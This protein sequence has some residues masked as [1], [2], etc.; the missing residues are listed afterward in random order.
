[1][2]MSEMSENKAWF[3]EDNGQ[4]KG[5]VDHQEI[6]ELIKI[7]KITYGTLV[8]RSGFSEWQNVENTDLKSQLAAFSPPHLPKRHKN[9]FSL[10]GRISLIAICVLGVVFYYSLEKKNLDFNLSQIEITDERVTT[11]YG[12]LSIIGESYEKKILWDDREIY[13]SEGMGMSLEKAFSFE[14]EDVVLVQEFNGGAAC[15]A[16]FFFVILNKKQAPKLTPGFGTCSDL[17][18]TKQDGETIQV[19]M[20]GFAGP[21]ETNN[22]RRRA[23]ETT[24]IY[25]LN[26]GNV[27]EKIVPLLTDTT[28]NLLTQKDINIISTILRKSKQEA[29]IN[30]QKASCYEAAIA[31]RER[32]LVIQC[33]T[34]ETIAFKNESVSKEDFEARVE[35][36]L[37]ILETDS[38]KRQQL[39]Q[40]ILTF[41]EENFSGNIDNK[42]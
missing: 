13:I 14:Q 22:T 30:S 11:S 3:F 2:N 19:S 27:E 15:P 32:S 33:A 29:N 4:K 37:A 28:K 23:A 18:D 34:L 7:G 5:P 20:P 6:I 12:V 10:W 31:I 24:H 8:W 17:A 25:R 26:Q 1:M 41:V 9:N 39:R 35:N 40:E 21:F 16:Q 42:E 36:V 38:E